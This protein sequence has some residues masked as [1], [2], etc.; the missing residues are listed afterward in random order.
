MY[1]QNQLSTNKFDRNHKINS[2]DIMA[3]IID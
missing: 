2:N 1:Y 3:F